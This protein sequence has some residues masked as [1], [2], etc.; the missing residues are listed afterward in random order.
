MSSSIN[1]LSD[2]YGRSFDTKFNR[3]MPGYHKRLNEQVADKNPRQIIPMS[4]ALLVFKTTG[5]MAVTALILFLASSL[6]GNYVAKAGHTDDKSIKQIIVGNDVISLPMNMIRYGNQRTKTTAQRL[7]LYAH[8]PSL[9]GYSADYKDAFSSMENDAPII[10]LTLEQRNMSLEMSGRVERIYEHF[11]AGPPIESV[12][13]LV[14]R[15]FSKDSAYFSED[16]YY[17]INSPYP[18]AT[19]CIRES[20]SVAAPFCIRDIHIGHGLTLTYRFHISLLKEWNTIE[21]A[22]KNKFNHMLA[23]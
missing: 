12:A 8:W 9:S 6:Y 19:R 18:Y 7:D 11:Y 10:F 3:E 17:E 21:R 1:I 23:N 15:P 16:L 14:R 2:N 20:D 22:I 4:F 13:G 5:F